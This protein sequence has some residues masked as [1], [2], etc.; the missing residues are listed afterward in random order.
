MGDNQ[1]VV[2][3]PVYEGERPMSKDNHLLGQFSLKGI[4][5]APRGTPQL[6]VT[7]NIDPNGIL[8]VQATDQGTGNTEKITITNDKGRLSEQQIEKMVREAEMF[9]E[10]DQKVKE[11]V[12]AK[13]AFDNYMHS[14]ETATEGSPGNKGLSEKLSEEE[15]ATIREALRDGHAWLDSNPE[16]DAEDIKEKQ[17][18]VEGI[19][20][21]IVSKHYGGSRGS[22]GGSAGD[23]EDEEEEYSNEL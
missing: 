7:F 16:A 20:A 18:D 13:N 1:P 21:P 5:P 8:H 23:S 15:K 10:Q 2:Q 22:D 4:P 12:D 14:M 19:C 11:R 3:F 6:E 17:K 9:A